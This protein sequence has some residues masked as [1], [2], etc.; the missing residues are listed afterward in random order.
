MLIS[1]RLALRPRAII[2]L[3]L[4]TPLCYFL[5]YHLKPAIQHHA[6]QRHDADH[7]PIPVKSPDGPSI[8]LVVATTAKDDMSWT[9]NL[10]IP[11]LQVIRYVSDSQSAKYHP[12]KPKGREALMYL[13][14]I[15]DF[16]DT[17]PDISIFIHAEENP[18][19]MDGALLESMTFALSH[20][21]FSQVIESRYFNLRV[22]WKHGCP[23]QINTSMTTEIDEKKQEQHL[24]AEAFRAIFGADVQVPEILA[25]ACCSQ[26]AVS[27]D[28]IRQRAKYEYKHYMDWLIETSWSD[29]ISGRV[30]EHLWP[31]IFLNRPIEC[32]IEWKSLC[33]MYGV[34][35]GGQNQLQKYQQV[36][37]ARRAVD[38]NVTFWKDV[39]RPKDT[40]ALRH[41]SEKYTEWL[42][43][44]LAAAL[45]SGKAAENRG[46]V[47][48]DLYTP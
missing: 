21:D 15:H 8:N 20:L 40:E 29:Y 23:A 1:R 32:P 28:A 43:E 38:G 35:F 45:T 34:C 42:H 12:S 44:R 5:L 22:N 37:D 27:R 2:I 6:V 47:L 25:G 36:W 39:W 11:H 3:L 26:F 24:M 30:F 13:T 16:Y 4:F 33:S 48:G 41:R 18:W 14:Y 10:R 17:L 31:Y 7:F 46:H 19:H 9:K